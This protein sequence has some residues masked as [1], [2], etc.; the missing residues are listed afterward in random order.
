MDDMHNKFILMDMD[1][2]VRQQSDLAK[3]IVEDRAFTENERATVMGS[4][5][6]HDGGNKGGDAGRAIVFGVL[7][8]GIHRRSITI[9]RP[10]RGEFI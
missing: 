9:H 7:H 8:G 6:G 2:D 1:V 3:E 4:H 5:G 10:V